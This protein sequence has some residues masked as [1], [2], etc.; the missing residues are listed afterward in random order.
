MQF[1]LVHRDAD[2]DSV[3]EALNGCREFALDCEAAGF[4]RYTDT[5]CLVQLSTPAAHF[6][7]DPLEVDP[8]PVL[9]GPLQDPDI[10]VVMHGADFDMRLISR[11]LGLTV[12]GL[13]DTQVAA[14]LTGEPQV[15]LSALLEKYL[16]VKLS[17]KY[18]RADWARRPL[19]DGMLAYAIADTA[20]LMQLRQVLREAVRDAG[21][22]AWVQ[23]EL[24]LLQSVRWEAEEDP[25]D[26]VVRVKHARKL[27]PRALDALRIGLDWRDRIARAMDRAPF[28]VAGDSALMGVAKERPDSLE[29]LRTVKGMPRGVVERH[30][31][32]LLSLLSEAAAKPESEIAPYPRLQGNGLGRPTPEEEER[33]DKLKAARNQRADELGLERGRVFSNASLLEVARSHPRTLD[34]IEALGL[35][36]RWQVEAVGP[37]LLASLDGVTPPPPLP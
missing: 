30:G 14:A 5:L 34:E 36:R 9:E 35:A 17:K 24:E 26:P 31:P 20:H 13:F 4:H 8:T 1:T 3:G 27:D 6:I 37:A 12:R 2:L 11:D 10:E 32:E 29:G 25:A 18:Q 33:F 19:D 28:R 23:E 21:R 22:E 16:D 15:G 7:I